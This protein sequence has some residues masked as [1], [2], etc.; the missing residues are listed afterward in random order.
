MWI[1]PPGEKAATGRQ[2]SGGTVCSAIAIIMVINVALSVIRA[3]TA[4]RRSLLLPGTC[5]GPDQ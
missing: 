2:L 4:Y 1:F 5:G 3:T